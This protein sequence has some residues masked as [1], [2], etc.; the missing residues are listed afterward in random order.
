MITP[1]FSCSQTS[2][3]VIVSIYCPSVRA[4]EVEIHVDET[5]L[6]VHIS[7]YFLRLNFPGNVLEDENSSAVYDP[8]TGYLTVTLTKEEKGQDFPDLDLLAKLL[9]PKPVQTR[10][11]QGPVIEVLASHE[12]DDADEDNDQELVDRARGLSLDE[13]GLTAEQREILEA[14]ANDWQMP[15]AVPEPCRNCTPPSKKRYGFLDMYT[16]YFQYVTNTENEV[17]ELGADAETLPLDERRRRR[18]QH[19]DEKWDE[20]Y[21]M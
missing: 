3:S 2:D 4:S 19:E 21:Y 8:S 6:S 15:Q 11:P 14:A 17:N 7:P 16:G 13:A 10:A 9:A 1:R 12:A 18:I 5:L 20:D